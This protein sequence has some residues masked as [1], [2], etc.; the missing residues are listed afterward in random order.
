MLDQHFIDGRLAQIRIQG[1]PADG[2][3]LLEG[4]LEF[5]V[6]AV[7]LFDD[8][9]QP[10]GQLGHPLFEFA[11]RLLEA[12][13]VGL[14]MAVEG[15]EQVGKLPRIVQVGVEGLL[16]ILEED[17]SPGVLEDD[18]VERVAAGRFLADFGREVVV[19][20]FGLPIA[21][22]QIEFV[23]ERAVGIDRPAAAFDGLLGDERQAVRLGG[24]AEQLLE[25][26][27]EGSF[28]RDILRG[29]GLEGL[30]VGGQRLVCRLDGAGRHVA[31]GCWNYSA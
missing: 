31:R 22:G 29:V 6:V 19:G 27:F 1:S 2:E 26:G 23:A 30:V 9:G 13:D 21:V 5:G 4:G 16:A 10:L 14:G 18:V 25:G 12:F 15:V 8:R 11:D 7:G 17:G 24:F 28:M 20:V 3:E